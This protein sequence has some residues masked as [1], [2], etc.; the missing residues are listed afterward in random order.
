MKEGKWCNY[1]LNK[2]SKETKSW[3]K[4]RSGQ[5]QSAK[6]FECA[7]PEKN[8]WKRAAGHPLISSRQNKNK[9]WAGIAVFACLSAFPGQLLLAFK[10][11]SQLFLTA[12]VLAFERLKFWKHLPNNLPSHDF[13][14]L[15]ASVLSKTSALSLRS[16]P[17]LSNSLPRLWD[18]CFLAQAFLCFEVLIPEGCRS[19]G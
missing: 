1:L 14:T 12:K 7:P 13:T 3:G 19:F 10:L 15:P 5:T 4:S 11:L 6:R 2:F 16:L 18:R 8:D 17:L 9:C